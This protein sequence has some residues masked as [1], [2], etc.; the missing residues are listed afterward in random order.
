MQLRFSINGTKTM[1]I[2]PKLSSPRLRVLIIDDEANIRITLSLCLEADGHDAIA[3]DS[4]ADSIEAI[5]RQAFDLVFLDVRLGLDNGLDFLPQLRAESPWAKVVVITAYASIET[6]VEAMR[7]GAT[8]YLPKPFDA[9]QVQIL[10]QKISDQRQLER[11]AL[12]LQSALGAIEPLDDP[13]STS[14]EVCKAIEIATQVAASKTPVLI[15]GEPG[16]GKR[17]LARMIHA[18][19]P[20]AAGPMAT[21]SCQMESDMLEAELFGFSP[22]HAPVSDATQVDKISL[23]DTG[24][25]VLD[26]VGQT[27]TR[28]QPKL[29]QLI[30]DKQYERMDETRARPADVRIISTTSQNLAQ[31]AHQGFLRTDLKLALEI[32]PIDLPPLRNRPDD[33]PPLA[34]R[35]LALFSRETNR[36]AIGFTKDALY[37]LR[38]YHWPGNVRELRNVIERA[39]LLCRENE[40]G[41]KHLP[42]NLLNAEPVYSI[43]DLV[44]LE[45]IKLAHIRKVL[46]STRSIRRAAAVLGIDSSTLCRIMK[47]YDEEK[48]Q[49]AA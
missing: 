9:A 41:V 34:E 14:P 42:A 40:I 18:L 36:L 20:R 49:P 29:L 43:G 31:A 30:Q 35:F 27:P 45:D 7:R 4:I 22:A 23:C 46:A 13:A 25:L 12:A 11:R 28:L 38:Q 24:T 1:Q 3:V 2:N 39:V 17:R 16:T 5:A 15:R 48:D 26:E 21:V 32:I 47:R 44:P 37:A 6:A 8:D 10:T 33:I 19:G